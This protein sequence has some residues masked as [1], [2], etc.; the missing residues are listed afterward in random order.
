M[1]A[2]DCT[3]GERCSMLQMRKSV[4]YGRESRAIADKKSALCKVLQQ[5]FSFFLLIKLICHQTKYEIQKLGI[6]V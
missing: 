4:S 6:S 5:Y 2:N 3:A 1:L